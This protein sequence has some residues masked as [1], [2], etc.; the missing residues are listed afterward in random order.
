MSLFC[1]VAAKPV[2]VPAT[3]LEPATR[4]SPAACVPFTVS[5]LYCAPSD[6]EAARPEKLYDAVPLT[7]PVY[8][9][10]LYGFDVALP[11]ARRSGSGMRPGWITWRSVRPA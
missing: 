10:K 2:V 7:L 6:V 11:N 3:E 1:A 4:P 5:L 8:V 9:Q